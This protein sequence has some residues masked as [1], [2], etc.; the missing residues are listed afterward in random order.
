MV[1]KTR[2]AIELTYNY[3]AFQLRARH[4]VRAHALGVSDIRAACDAIRKPGE[5][6]PANRDR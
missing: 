3:G 6:L 5:R 4:G 2:T 1:R